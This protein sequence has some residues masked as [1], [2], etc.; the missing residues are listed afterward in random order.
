M[1]QSSESKGFYILASTALPNNLLR[2][3]VIL[4]PAF[5]KG[6]SKV[7]EVVTIEMCLKAIFFK[8]LLTITFYKTTIHLHLM[9]VMIV[10]NN[11]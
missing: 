9:M 6:L 2:Q 10:L 3:G 1:F 7:T 8:V 4:A 11:F 5:E